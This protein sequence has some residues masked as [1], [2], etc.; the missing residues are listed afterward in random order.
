MN[1][2]MMTNARFFFGLSVPLVGILVNVALI[3][4]VNGRIAQLANRVHSGH[5]LLIGKVGEVGEVDSRLARVEER[6]AK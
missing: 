5:D 1:A 2:I 6:L 4:L 3:V